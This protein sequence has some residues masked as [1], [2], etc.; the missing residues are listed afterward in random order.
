MLPSRRP[1]VTATNCVPCHCA[2]GD[3]L[4]A[5]EL[6][7]E[8]DALEEADPLPPDDP[9]DPDELDDVLAGDAGDAALEFALAGAFAEAVELARDE[10]GAE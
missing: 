4:L 10:S 1:G 5:S 6:D 2:E 8:V 9:D 7:A 3:E